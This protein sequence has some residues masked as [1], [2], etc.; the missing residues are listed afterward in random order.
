MAAR[1][2]S[3]FFLPLLVVG[4]SQQ[5]AMPAEIRAAEIRPEAP[6]EI[7]RP[8]P[9]SR[10]RA[11]HEATAARS[12]HGRARLDHTINR[13]STFSLMQP[14]ATFSG[15]RLPN[16][17]NP[18]WRSQVD[19]LLITQETTKNEPSKGEPT[20]GDPTKNEPS[21]SEPIPLAVA[22]HEGPK[23]PERERS[24]REANSRGVSHMRGHRVRNE[25]GI[26]GSGNQG[27][28]DGPSV[29]VSGDST[30]DELKG[31]VRTFVLH[32]GT[33]F[34]A[35][36]EPVR[37][38]T[39]RG[40]VDI[41]GRS[42]VYVV[43]LG[44]SVAVYNIA[45][46]KSGDVTVKTPGQ[47]RVTLKAGE[48]VLLADKESADFNKANPAPEI[49]STR[50]KELG[51][52]AGTKIFNAEFSPTAALDHAQRFQEMVNSKSKSDRAFVDHI[53]KTA[54]IV[55]TLRASGE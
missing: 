11:P 46:H 13:L 7:T 17:S 51:T 35:H 34:S 39:D 38:K 21:K 18:G 31:N 24:G 8:A 1:F 12:A 28:G 5:L 43:S 10:V 27:I 41:A 26:A 20:K 25:F 4:L 32:N 33:A 14:A 6:R 48:Q 22:H 42:V 49:R 45:D 53:L 50:T 52:E 44:K 36:N 47:R 55:L 15:S 2:S 54:A 16:L 30:P 37:I 19:H 29:N 9:V 40:E 23:R 3:G